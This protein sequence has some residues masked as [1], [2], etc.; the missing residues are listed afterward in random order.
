MA[1]RIEELTEEERAALE[2]GM[3]RGGMK[4]LRLLDAH[5]ADRAA[6]V[7][8][9]AELGAA[10][11]NQSDDNRPAAPE[12]YEV[13][14]GTEKTKE[15]IVLE[16]DDIEEAARAACADASCR[17]FWGM[18]TAAPIDH[19]R[20]VLEAMARIPAESF[21]WCDGISVTLDEAIKAELA[22]REAKCK[23]EKDA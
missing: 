23:G 4:A 11:R 3:C 19:D 7:A 15:S 13:W 12:R 5:A 20:A 21:E 18:K 6:L 10:L 22:R 16:T 1:E 14:V 8:R 2:S 17:T 9:V